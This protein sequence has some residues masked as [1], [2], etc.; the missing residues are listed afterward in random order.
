[1]VMAYFEMTSPH[2]TWYI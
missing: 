1:M 2:L